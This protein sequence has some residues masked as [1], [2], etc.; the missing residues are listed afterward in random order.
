MGG[1]LAFARLGACQHRHESLREGAL[2]KQSAQQIGDPEGD[3]KGIGQAAGAKQGSH[4]LL[5]DQTG[6]ARSKGQQ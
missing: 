1:G 4:Q 2:G 5:T 6:N 3:L